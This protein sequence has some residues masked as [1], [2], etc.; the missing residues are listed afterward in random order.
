MSLAHRVRVNVAAFTA[1]A[2]LFTPLWSGAK[3]LSSTLFTLPNLEQP[4]ADPID[5]QSEWL[6]LT[7]FDES[8]LHWN[9]FIR[10]FVNNKAAYKA[11]ANNYAQYLVWYDAFEE[12]EDEAPAPKYLS[13]PEGTVLLK[14][15]YLKSDG[16]PGDPM[17]LS[18]MV[19]REKGYDPQ[20]GDWEYLQLLPNGQTIMRGNSKDITVAKAC[21]ACHAN[22]PDKDFVFSSF[23]SQPKS[24]QDL[25]ITAPAQK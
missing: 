6:K 14:E 16:K 15:N 19:K 13:Y 17:V 3:E 8:G 7:G 11:Y 1:L 22:V 4:S 20:F 2:L 23:L 24:V 25:S 9:S 10:I 21:Q 18:L 12:D 5:Y